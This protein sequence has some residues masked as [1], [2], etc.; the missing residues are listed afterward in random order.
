M[1][2]QKGI[3]MELDGN[4]SVYMLADGRFV[5]GKPTAGT[6]V[7]E[8][9]Y[10]EP[11]KVSNRRFKPFA[12]PL[13]ASVA[14][15]FLFI[16]TWVLPADE[17]Y[18]YVQVE[19]N[20]GIEIG[21][22][23]DWQVISMREL[24]EDG[25]RLIAKLAD[26]ENE[27]F[28]TVLQ[29]VLNLSVDEDTEHV[30]IT[31]VQEGD[32]TDATVKVE[33]IAL[34]ALFT[35]NNRALQIHL[36]EANKKQWREAKE[37]QVPVA[38]L[39]EKDRTFTSPRSQENDVQPAQNEGIKEK[40]ELEDQE[41]PAKVQQPEPPKAKK[42]NEPTSIN[43]NKEEKSKKADTQSKPASDKNDNN[44]VKEPA[45]KVPAAPKETKKQEKPEPV[46]PKSSNAGEGN[47][48]GNSK[49]KTKPKTE[50]PS[51]AEQP[52]QES[53]SKGNSVPG[54]PKDQEN[55]QDKGKGNSNNNGKENSNSNNNGKSNNGKENSNSNNNGNSS[56]ADKGKATP[57]D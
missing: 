4:R 49:A 31:T 52:K 29:N 25:K 50:P 55:K 15:L 41:P 47:N 54:K 44:K 23:D 28:E 10:F 3:C 6:V 8:E 26:W 17:A 36:K 37:Q 16:S 34:A 19:S 12:M 20:P 2:M 35:G 21:V 48:S 46:K 27:E 51:K 5:T 56:K 24:N 45:V 43:S 32:G 53:K 9:A 40:Q 22:D 38:R 30:T 14:A 39:I 11:V 33:Q 1:Q 57:K 42:E 18:G 13:I 7:G